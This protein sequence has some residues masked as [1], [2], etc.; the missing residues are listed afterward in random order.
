MIMKGMSGG[1][2]PTD[3]GLLPTTFIPRPWERSTGCTR[4]TRKGFCL[5]YGYVLDGYSEV[6]LR[7]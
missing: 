6:L 2:L 1:K 7:M 5:S 3:I 4:M